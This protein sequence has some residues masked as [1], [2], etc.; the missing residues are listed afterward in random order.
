[1]SIPNL[2]NNLIQQ[3]N[4][5]MNQVP[6]GHAIMTNVNATNGISLATALTHAPTTVDQSGEIKIVD[7]IP[8]AGASLVGVPNVPV[9]TASPIKNAQTTMNTQEG[10]SQLLTKARL[11]DLVRDT[12]PT[13]TLEDEVEEA[14]L[15]YTDDFLDRVLNGAAMIAKH[16]HVNTIEVKD[17]QQFLN[18]N[19][20]I[21]APGFGTDELRPYKR[22]MT[23]ESHKQRLALIRK[24]LKKY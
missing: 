7:T 18:R 22:S 5:V 23:A 13:L 6:M 9:Q 4:I 14:L 1:M 17:V 10:M 21:W 20:G 24:A 19:Y 11:N 15:A 3:Q 16:R 8:I 12:D 2:T